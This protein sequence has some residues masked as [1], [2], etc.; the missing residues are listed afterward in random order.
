M[1]ELRPES[2]S[3]RT[4]T[5]IAGVVLVAGATMAVVGMA[6]VPLMWPMYKVGLVSPACGL[7]RG[8]VEVFRGNFA[9]A[10][11]FNPAS[12]VVVAGAV[13]LVARFL[14][15]RRWTSGDLGSFARRP[16]TIVSIGLAIVVLWVN[17]QANADFVINARV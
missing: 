9:R 15:T 17:Q 6:D 7:T 4:P 16:T 13:F 12:F 14:V 5:L 10:W 3:T 11:R 8:V 2:L 1:T